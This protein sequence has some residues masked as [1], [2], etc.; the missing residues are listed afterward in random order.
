MNAKSVFE[1]FAGNSITTNLAILLIFLI[2]AGI[3][4][5]VF[6]RMGGKENNL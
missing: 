5:N 2:A 4:A 3:A 6:Y 1:L